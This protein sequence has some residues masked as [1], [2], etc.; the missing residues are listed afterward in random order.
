MDKVK[1]F[2]QT[3]SKD[4]CPPLC[5]RAY[6]R[7]KADDPS[8]LFDDEGGE[9]FVML[10]DISAKGIGVESSFPLIPGEKRAVLVKSAILRE[11]AKKE[12]RVVW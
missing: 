4:G 8:V 6:P 7:V 10:R 9:K 3:Y 11:L 2:E 12:A 5:R 1:A